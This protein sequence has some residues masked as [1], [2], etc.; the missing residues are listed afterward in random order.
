MLNI[1]SCNYQ[2]GRQCTCNLTMRDV[3]PFVELMDIVAVWLKDMFLLFFA[4]LFC[5]LY[6]N[7]KLV[8]SR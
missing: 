2:T 1:N 7:L 4:G 8:S 6:V 3:R 5:V